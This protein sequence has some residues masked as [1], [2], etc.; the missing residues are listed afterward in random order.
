MGEYELKILS[1]LSLIAFSH[2]GIAVDFRHAD[3]LFSQRGIS[4]EGID[5]IDKAL[6]SYTQL[7]NGSQGPLTQREQIYAVVQKSRLYVYHGINQDKATDVGKNRRRTLFSK[8]RQDL[9][10]IHPSNVGPTPE[11][12]HYSAYCLIL[13]AAVRPVVWGLSRIKDIKNLIAQGMK[14]ETTFEGGGILRVA[15]G[16]HSTPELRSVPGIWDPELAWNLIQQAIDSEPYGQ[17]SLWGVDYCYNWAGIAMGL[18][19]R[20]KT[21]EALSEINDS[22]EYWQDLEQNNALPVGIEPESRQCL[23]DMRLVA[24]KLR[25]KIETGSPF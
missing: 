18:D 22:L 12:Y 6:E 14:L 21:R 8:C 20:G 4:A 19:A 3:R 24:D 16:L 2:L 5:S 17:S 9:Q 10:L 7:I 25:S 11:Y 1:F 23:R 13:E 15:A